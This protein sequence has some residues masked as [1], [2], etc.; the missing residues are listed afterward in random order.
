[1]STKTHLYEKFDHV[2]Y[3]VTGTKVDFD[4]TGLKLR[5]DNLFEGV[6]VLGKLAS[7][8]SAIFERSRK[9]VSLMIFPTEIFPFH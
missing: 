3:N 9:H 7:I 1:M 4:L 2:F 8:S 5:L 6:T